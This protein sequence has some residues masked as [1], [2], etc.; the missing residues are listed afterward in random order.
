MIGIYYT[1]HCTQKG[2]NFMAQQGRSAKYKGS[3]YER[4]IAKL[5]SE[6]FHT[7]VQR[8]AYSGAGRGIDTQY[9]N[10]EVKGEN[11][12][13]GDLFFPKTH[14]MSIFN[15]ELKNHAK[16]KLAQFFNNNGEIPSFLEQV[17][18]DSRRLG[19]VGHSVP[20]LV[21]HV[22]REDDYVV[23]P[24][25]GAIYKELLSYGPAMITVLSYTQERTQHTYKYQMLITNLATFMQLSPQHVYQAYKD[26]DYDRLNHHQSAPKKLDINKLVKNIR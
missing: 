24:Y 10:S 20:C 11:G 14:P 12:F 13:V 1:H 25:R 3:A 5:M 19:G 2:R 17:T 26:Y 23:F 16:V 7:D 21:V 4:K 6:G 22:E 9:N 8:T 15:Y 18:T